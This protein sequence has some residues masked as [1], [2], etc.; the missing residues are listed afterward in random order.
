V[1][2]CK[3]LINFPVNGTGALLLMPGDAAKGVSSE[4][5]TTRGTV[6]ICKN[7]AATV[8]CVES[9]VELVLCRD[10]TIG[11]LRHIDPQ[12]AANHAERKSPGQ[13]QGYARNLQGA[14]HV[15]LPHPTKMPPVSW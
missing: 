2:I 4:P 7:A 11:D 12:E 13:S 5:H 9:A 10:C 3:H 15:H 1:G 6:D 14:I 8:H